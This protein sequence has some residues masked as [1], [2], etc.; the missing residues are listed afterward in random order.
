MPSKTEK[1]LSKQEQKHIEK[2]VEKHV[3]KKIS[4]Q[5]LTKTEFLSHLFKQ[6]VSTAVIAAFSFLMALIWKDLIVHYIQKTFPGAPHDL[7]S[8]VIVTIVAVIGILIISSWAKK[9]QVIQSETKTI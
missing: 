7:V 2:H 6:H 1:Q 4:D 3:D 8:A 5:L 9:P